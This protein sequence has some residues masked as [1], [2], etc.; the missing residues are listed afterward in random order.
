MQRSVELGK[1][2]PLGI[3]EAANQVTLEVV[4]EIQLSVVVVAL[5]SVICV[6]FEIILVIAEE[7]FDQLLI[8]L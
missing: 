3:P 8:L 7:S 6:F 1:T 2:E 4:I 5:D